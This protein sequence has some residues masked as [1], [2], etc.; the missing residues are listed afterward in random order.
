M[1][2]P[3][4]SIVM[5]TY[6]GAAYL[7][8]ALE[9]I[10]VQQMDDVEI[11]A[12]DDGS[13]DDTFAILTEFETPLNLQILTRRV[14]NWAANSNHGLTLARG[15]FV[16]FLHQDDF[17]YPQRLQLVRQQLHATPEVKLLLHACEFVDPRGHPLGPWRCPYPRAKP[18]TPAFVV[19]RLLVQ[20]FV[21]M[22]GATFHRETALKVGGLDESLWYTADWDL[23]LTL[24]LVGPTVYL[25]QRLGAF[26]LHPQ[27]QTADRS[28]SGED[29][30]QQMHLMTQRHAAAWPV[31][32]A[33]LRRDVLATAQASVEIN[34]ALAAAYH[35]QSVSWW[36]LATALM[37]LGFTNWPRLLRDSRL[38]ER[39]TA[40]LR[41]GFAK[42][43]TR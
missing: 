4:L 41:A 18:M 43:S 42:S 9:S 23:W 37:E 17:W 19:E 28:R 33:Q 13:T 34:V 2:A 35:Q 12:I 21:G 26:R 10:A 5:P 36:R 30:R 38:M 14:G 31:T 29:F 15:A 20:N 25:P 3:W 40:R 32:D 39:V 1:S 11:I 8:Q 6:N 16:C 27:S 22:P 7:R 24:A